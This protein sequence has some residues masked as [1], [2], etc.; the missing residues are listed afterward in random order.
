M[1]KLTVREKEF[2]RGQFDDADK[3]YKKKAKT[4]KHQSHKH[5]TISTSWKK[6]AEEDVL[7]E[8][9]RRRRRPRTLTGQ[10]RMGRLGRQDKVNA[11]AHKSTF[12]A[13]FLNSDLR[14]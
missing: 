7:P 13:S 10:A 3:V 6:D 12:F 4:R 8:S 9:P 14:A 5:S 11:H 1:L 2:S